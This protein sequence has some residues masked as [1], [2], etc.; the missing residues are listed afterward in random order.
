MW[1]ILTGVGL[2]SYKECDDLPTLGVGEPCPFTSTLQ[3]LGFPLARWGEE[4]W[5]LHE[6]LERSGAFG[7][8]SVSLQ[9][10]HVTRFP[11][12]HQ[13]VIPAFPWGLLAAVTL[14]P[15][16]GGA[17][18]SSGVKSGQKNKQTTGAF[19][20]HRGLVPLHKQCCLGTGQPGSSCP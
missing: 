3:V 7:R 18:Q 1:E 15:G 10:G 12:D 17:Q 16:R 2:E 13:S 4:G 11:R 20:E 14:L 9:A 19:E 8:I 5:G 6:S